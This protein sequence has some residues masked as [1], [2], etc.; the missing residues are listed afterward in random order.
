M[1]KFM[2]FCQQV[3]AAY[4]IEDESDE[5]NEEEDERDDSYRWWPQKFFRKEETRR[6]AIDLHRSKLKKNIKYI[7]A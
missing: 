4:A 2:K 3:E 7:N 6:Q 1:R 5:D